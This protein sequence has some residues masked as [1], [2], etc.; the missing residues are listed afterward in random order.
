MTCRCYAQGRHDIARRGGEIE[1][2]RGVSV[3]V[4]GVD[5][6]V[7][8]MIEF[9]ELDSQLN[10]NTR[11]CVLEPRKSR[12]LSPIRRLCSGEVLRARDTD[13]KISHQ[14]IP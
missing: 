3:R 6:A 2:A 8:S 14:A 11:I 10:L 7:R 13:L 5:R 4:S 12:Q 1:F 9:G